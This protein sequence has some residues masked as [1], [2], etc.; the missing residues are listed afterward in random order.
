MAIEITNAHRT[1][2]ELFLE[3]YLRDSNPGINV[4]KGTA[5]RDFLVMAMASVVAFLRQETDKVRERQSVRGVRLMPDGVDKDQA[6]D[7]LASNQFLTR[8]PGKVSRGVAEIHSS[9]PVDLLIKTTDVFNRAE[10]L[11]FAADIT[12]DTVI[13]ASEFNSVRNNL[14]LVT[15]WVATVPLRAMSVGVDA[16]IGPGDFY[17]TSL[18]SPYITRVVNP[19]AFA[20][21]GEPESTEELLNRIPV[22]ISVR[23]LVTDRAAKTVLTDLFSSVDSVSVVGFGDPEMQRDRIEAVQGITE[24]HTGGHVD[25]YISS[26]VLEMKSV[27]GTVGGLSEDVRPRVTIFRD[28]LQDFVASGVVQGDILKVTNGLGGEASKYLITEVFT[29]YLRVSKTAPFPE[30]RSSVSYT[31]GSNYPDYDSKLGAGAPI[32]TGEYSRSFELTKKFLLPQHP[33]LLIRDVAIPDTSP[34]SGIAGVDGWIHFIN[35]VNVAPSSN[36]ADLEYRV[37]SL[38]PEEVPSAMQLLLVDIPAAEDLSAIRVVYDTQAEYDSVNTYVSAK[39]NRVASASVLT[40]GFHP[41]YLK[42]RLLV[43]MNANART[44]VNLSDIRQAVVNYIGDRPRWEVVTVSDIITEVKDKFKDLE[45]VIPVA[46]QSTPLVWEDTMLLTVGSV[47]KPTGTTRDFYDVI[48]GGTTGPVEPV[49]ATDMSTVITDGTV[50]YRKV[51]EY[52]IAYD[53]YSPDGRVIPYRTTN[54]VSLSQRFLLRPGVI[55]DALDVTGAVRSTAL[56]LSSR[57]IKYLTTLDLIEAEYV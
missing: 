44:L 46:L 25:L 17:S 37:V 19:Q 34:P 48:A 6:A 38:N 33:V 40:K 28:D 16:N 2:A 31:I 49:W 8:K 7:D 5:L 14:G 56:G 43:R 9:Q 3:Q 13:S 29:K 4:S 22:A 15:H 32:T 57:T 54:E 12:S 41:C 55:T 1:E 18:R 27:T 10:N 42:T 39:M 11:S 21:G 45:F 36:V 30:T 24:V 51:P 47:V 35:R 53:L 52:S 50:S 26:P 20:G 23:D